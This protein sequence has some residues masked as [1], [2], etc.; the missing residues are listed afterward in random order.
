MGKDE[1]V[2]LLKDAALNQNINKEQKAK[3]LVELLYIFK[4]KP[5]VVESGPVKLA[6]DWVIPVGES[7]SGVQLIG[8]DNVTWGVERHYKHSDAAH[9]KGMMNLLVSFRLANISNDT[10]RNKVLEKCQKSFGFNL[11]TTSTEMELEYVREILAAIDFMVALVGTKAVSA[12]RFATQIT[13][14]MSQAGQRDFAYVMSLFPGKITP[15]MFSSHPELWDEIELL[16]KVKPD[17]LKKN[18]LFPYMTSLGYVGKSRLSARRVPYIHNFV[19]FL[20]VFAGQGRLANAQKMPDSGFEDM[21]RAAL[22]IIAMLGDTSQAIFYDPDNPVSVKKIA[23][24]GEQNLTTDKDVFYHINHHGIELQWGRVY[25]FIKSKATTLGNSRDNSIGKFIYESAI[26][27]DVQGAAAVGVPHGTGA[28][29]GDDSRGGE[30]SR[31]RKRTVEDPADDMDILGDDSDNI[32]L[33]AMLK[34]RGPGV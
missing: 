15:L 13:Q 4:S 27:M 34:Q 8:L 12:Y 7:L 24:M 18:S 33:S 30:P 2:G 28:P 25:S 23:E 32:T 5:L 10:H 11:T 21:R 16:Q 3:M 20:G 31:K 19:H 14:Y 1:F 17:M 22:A 26:G 6:G 29:P 9:F